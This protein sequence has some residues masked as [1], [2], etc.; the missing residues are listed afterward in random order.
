MELGAFLELGIEMLICPGKVLF[1]PEIIY[2]IPHCSGARGGGLGLGEF[3][4]S[5]QLIIYDEEAGFTNRRDGLLDYN[6][7]LSLV[8]G[9]YV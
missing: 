8:S 3:G 4:T 2:P 5:L 1:W 6:A 9:V 7:F